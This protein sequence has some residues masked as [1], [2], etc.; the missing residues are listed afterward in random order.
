MPKIDLKRLIDHI[1]EAYGQL[2]ADSM[3][4]IPM[5]GPVYVPQPAADEQD[6]SSMTA[7]EPHLDGT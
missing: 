3:F 1:L 6:A 4:E 7:D 2:P 5:M